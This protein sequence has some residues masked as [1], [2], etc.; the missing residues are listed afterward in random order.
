[1]VTFN[2]DLLD[3]RNFS[4]LYKFACIMHNNSVNQILLDIRSALIRELNYRLSDGLGCPLVSIDLE[5]TNRETIAEAIAA[6]GK[7]RI[8]FASSGHPRAVTLCSEL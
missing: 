7:A 6:I 3:E 2:F 8:H 1:M 4:A 5:D